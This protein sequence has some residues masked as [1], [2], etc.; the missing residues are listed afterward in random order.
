MGAPN[1]PRVETNKYYC[2]GHLNEERQDWD[3]FEW[4]SY[5]EMMEFFTLDR[6]NQI[7]QFREAENNREAFGTWTE[8][9]DFGGHQFP[10]TMQLYIFSG[11]YSGYVYDLG[12]MEVDG[13]ELPTNGKLDDESMP[14]V[15]EGLLYWENYPQGWYKM[16]AKNFTRKLTAI[17]DKMKADAEAIFE[18]LCEDKLQVACRFSNGE[19]WYERTA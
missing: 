3:Q 5:F 15:L 18:Q 9:I 6:F 4:A 10:V 1:F 2:F 11:R 14:E 17:R 19:T 12:C 16:Q 8:Y 13:V 7:K